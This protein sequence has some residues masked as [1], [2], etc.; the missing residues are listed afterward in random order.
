[1]QTWTPR[2]RQCST[3]SLIGGRICPIS[4]S[5]LS[6]QTPPEWIF[7]KVWSKSTATICICVVRW[8]NQYWL[9]FNGECALASFAYY[10][11]KTFYCI[12]AHC[13][14]TKLVP[15]VG[16]SDE[17]RVFVLFWIGLFGHKTLIIVTHWFFNNVC[18][19][20]VFKFFSPDGTFWSLS[21]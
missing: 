5:M 8:I 14:V 2:L 15:V 6:F 16:C 7:M 1:M 19:Y 11:S 18:F 9:L 21:P 20:K 10:S 17:E 4:L 13:G 3:N 12:T